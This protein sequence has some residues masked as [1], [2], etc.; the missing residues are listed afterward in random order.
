MLCTAKKELQVISVI[1]VNMWSGFS[2][3]LLQVLWNQSLDA[4]ASLVEIIVTHSLSKAFESRISNENILV[5]D[6]TRDIQF[7]ISFDIRSEI[8]SKIW[9]DIR[10]GIWPKIQ[11]F[12]P[13]S[14]P[15]F[16]S[17][18][19]LEVL[20]LSKSFQCIYVLIFWLVWC[21]QSSELEWADSRLR[22]GRFT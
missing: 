10:V 17:T 8:W 4:L 5:I 12:D 3:Y 14:V 7:D 11:T 20:L 19:Q 9:F 1:R 21:I 2:G 18:S 22:Q 16:D 15:T 13:T 6:N